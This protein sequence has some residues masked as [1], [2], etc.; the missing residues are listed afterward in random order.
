MKRISV[1][2]YWRMARTR[3]L[4]YPFRY[5]SQSHLFDLLRSTDTHFWLPRS[6]YVRE[7]SNIGDAVHYVACPTRSIL[8]SLRAIEAHAGSSFNSFQFIDLGCGKGKALLV[9]CEYTRRKDVSAAVGIELLGVLAGIAERNVRIRRLDRRAKVVCGDAKGWR[10]Q[11][12]EAYAILFLYNPFGVDTLQAVL[13]QANGIDCYV[14]YIDPEH[15][16]VIERSGWKK[17]FAISGKYP[18]DCIEVWKNSAS[19]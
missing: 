10:F 1:G 4:R 14:A 9:Y 17:I 2:D 5:F 18:N 7:T 3:G 6:D 15:S 13:D 19:R 11:C 16:Q 8:A 12:S